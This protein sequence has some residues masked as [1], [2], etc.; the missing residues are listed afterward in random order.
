MATTTVTIT[1]GAAWAAL[2][3][4]EEFASCHIQVTSPQP[5][6]LAVATE[7]PGP[8]SSGFV[9]IGNAQPLVPFT[10]ETDEV[11]WGRGFNGDATVRIILVAVPE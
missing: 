5:L 6:A 10:L 8:T 2:V 9:L 3:D 7:E 1:A 4:G 11:I